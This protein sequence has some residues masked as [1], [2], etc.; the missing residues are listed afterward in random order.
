MRNC[1]NGWECTRK[2]GK[3][4]ERVEM[5][6]RDVNGWECGWERTE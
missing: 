3:R 6:E 1:G 4:W 5:V 2:D